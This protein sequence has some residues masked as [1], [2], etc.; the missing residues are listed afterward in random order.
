ME[1]TAKQRRSLQSGARITGPSRER[2]ISR[3]E[4]SLITDLV[5]ERA[6]MKS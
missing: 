1:G 5:T 2:W 3:R 4:S 6:R